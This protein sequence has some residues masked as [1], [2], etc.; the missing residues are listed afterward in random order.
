MEKY[1]RRL[2]C[3]LLVATVAACSLIA[4]AGSTAN[5][6][7]AANSTAPVGVYPAGI[8][9]IAPY[10]P[11]IHHGN[12]LFIS[13]QIPHVNGAIP[14]EAS[15]GKDDVKDQT[16]IVLA[17]VRA[18]LK[19]AGM[20]WANVVQV[21]GYLTDLNSFGDFNEVY[22]AVWKEAGIANPPARVVIEV[23][24]LPGGKPGAP[25]LVEIS[26]IAAR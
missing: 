10:S 14:P 17:N 26:A 5:A 24:K 21:T 23:S 19:E 12:L 6:Q 16:R 8:K 9:P 15:D 18:V 7:S 2:S 1:M 11:G 13:G 22:G 25:T 4:A 20:D 3:S